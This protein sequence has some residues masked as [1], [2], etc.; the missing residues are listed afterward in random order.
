MPTLERPGV[1][2]TQVITPASPTVVTPTLVP[3]IVGP[4]YQIV[5]PLK[6]GSLNSEARVATAAVLLSDTAWAG[7]AD[8]SGKTLK[9]TVNGVT[10]SVQ[11]P[12]VQ[13]GSLFPQAQIINTLNKQLT[14]AY[15]EYDSDDFLNIITFLKGAT[16]T[17]QIDTADVDNDADTP[18]L[19]TTDQSVHGN[20][21]YANLQYDA[22][23]ADMPNTKAP[24]IDDVVL[25]GEDL[26]VYR[27]YNNRL[28][29]C[30]QDKAVNWTSYIPQDQVTTPDSISRALS[31][32]RT[33][34]LVAAATAS[35]KTNTLDNLGTQA[36]VTIPLQHKTSTGS[37]LWPDAMGQNFLKVTALRV[38]PDT[39]AVNTALLGAAGN[40]SPAGNTGL[41]VVVAALGNGAAGVAFSYASPVL[42]ITNQTS[43]T[44]FHQ[45]QDA[46]AAALA[47][48][49]VK[50]VLNIEL[51]FA[52]AL[53]EEAAMGNTANGL[54]GTSWRASGGADAENFGADATAN[55]KFATLTGS[56]KLEAATT[57]A[58]LGIAG[59]TLSIS[60]NGSDWADVLFVDSAD[61]VQAQI[62]TAVT[63]ALGH[64]VADIQEVTTNK[65]GLAVD[66]LQLSS[67]L[68]TEVDGADSTIEVKA[69]KQ[70]VL[71]KLLGGEAA[72]ATRTEAIPG[73][74]LL[75]D[76]AAWGVA[77]TADTRARKLTLTS[78]TDYNKFAVTALEKAIQP[79]SIK[80][81]LARVGIRGF[82]SCTP[83]GP[84]PD[85]TG[86]PTNL[87]INHVDAAAAST[88]QTIAL[89]DLDVSTD[90]KL[91]NEIASA[92]AGGAL[93]GLVT[94]ALVGG[95]IVFG[96]FGITG[97]KMKLVSAGTHANI[98]AKLRGA[99]TVEVFDVFATTKQTGVV[100]LT[101]ST[102][103]AWQ[104]SSVGVGTFDN[105]VADPALP[106]S[107]SALT[108]LLL[109]P[110][111]SFC[112]SLGNSQK[113]N[114]EVGS[115]VWS[116]DTTGATTADQLPLVAHSL[117][118]TTATITYTRCAASALS[119]AGVAYAGRIFQAR[120]HKTL[121]GDTLYNKGVALGKV[122]AI[123]NSN[124]FTGN[125]LVLSDFTVAANA[126][127]TEWYCVAE[128]LTADSTRV[129]PE[130]VVYDLL[131]TLRVKHAL[132]RNLSGI[133]QPSRAGGPLY[134]GYRALRKD[135]TADTANPVLLAFANLDEVD[136][137]IGPVVPENPLAFALRTA[138][139]HTTDIVVAALG[140]AETSE[141]APDGTVDAYIQALDFLAIKEVY[142]LAPLTH[143]KAVHDKFGQHCY[144]MSAPAGRKERVCFVNIKLP[145]EKAPAAVVTGS[146]TIGDPIGT[147]Y[148]LTFGGDPAPNI[149]VA[150]SGKTKANGDVISGNDTSFT[151]E[152]GVYL[153]RAGDSYKYLV[154]GVSGSDVTIETDNVYGPGYGPSSGGNADNYFRVA[155]PVDF[156]VDG[157][158]CGIWVRQAAID[159]QTTGGK[160]A[161]CETLADLAG[162]ES[163]Y[164]NR[165]LYFSQ[166]EQLGI[167]YNGSEALVPGYH[168]CVADC[169]RSGQLSPSQPFTNLPYNGFTRVV[170]SSDKFSENQM[171]TAAA[172]GV[173]WVI[174]DV[175]GG[176]LT[177]RHQLST[178]VSLLKTREYSIVRSVD[179]VAKVIRAQVRRFIGRNNI[180]KSL[181]DVLG[182]SLSAALDSIIGTVVQGASV[183]S[184]QQD[185]SNPDTV[186]VQVSVKVFYPCNRISITIVA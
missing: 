16:A 68:F 160:L 33:I 164:Q 180:T 86:N 133:P 53:L 8:V 3:C 23:Y 157:E 52:A 175:P 96:A 176:S 121:V 58:Q 67:R 91:V 24:S 5:E 119:P 50:G 1:N 132:G 51:S 4:C 69:S 30:R 14:G 162:S 167:S 46:V 126:S 179:Y 124:G 80:L 57:V 12:V 144:D 184:I 65:V 83:L 70:S 161:V 153:E 120:P 106:T 125:R 117:A 29:A 41:K 92:I 31:Q 127:L 66:V 75:D 40:A 151:A 135:V 105:C 112:Y 77:G 173:W 181:L 159:M 150:L 13:Q 10:E 42:T 18:L 49:G 174:Q 129:Q 38:N 15:A 98:L 21:D 94:V 158:Q 48:P 11:F 100:T 143:D 47:A 166:P 177:C 104:V 130:L 93:A 110:S 169:A 90:Q 73:G 155:A 113:N 147:Q 22:R 142:A 54:I 34:P 116:G 108:A 136:A 146:A 60:V 128:G 6:D 28:I 71:D 32:W 122:M 64:D 36:S 35:A 99:N 84:A 186:V 89:K 170:G 111:C 134:V 168:A 88:S 26:T 25:K 97:S 103:G 85:V 7:N 178:D 95:K 154:V 78:V 115:L 17:I 45:L 118:G 20:A 87:V 82:I 156:E 81:E 43:G 101:D 131:Q 9:L 140:V 74:V 55:A 171:A 59:E 123:Q 183:D 114:N 56:A 141:D 182:L 107:A 72:S 163:G 109:D 61:T 19:F 172:G 145:T 39:G 139:F 2:I 63:A 76:A 62:N 79:G 137:M 152:D 44:T 165:R 102:A 149:N 148:V 37:L 138:F 27:H 185:P